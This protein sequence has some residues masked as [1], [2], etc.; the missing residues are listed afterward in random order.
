MLGR[1][2]IVYI[3]YYAPMNKLVHSS[4]MPKVILGIYLLTKIRS[5]YDL[6]MII[7]NC[8]NP[9]Y[10]S[11]GNFLEHTMLNNILTLCLLT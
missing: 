6:V 5:Q 8:F 4:E 10:H 1:G 2:C 7:Q 9:M 11:E 3:T